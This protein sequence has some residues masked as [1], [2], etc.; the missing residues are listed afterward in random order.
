MSFASLILFAAAG[1]LLGAVPA[2]IMEI[3]QSPQWSPAVLTAFGMPMCA[4]AAAGLL[5]WLITDW[6]RSSR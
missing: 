6:K 2:T 3:M 5:A 1:F 4:G